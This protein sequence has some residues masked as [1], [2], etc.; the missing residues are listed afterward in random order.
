MVKKIAV[1]AGIAILVSLVIT[2][3]VLLIKYLTRDEVKTNVIY[4]QV[5]DNTKLKEA[6]TKPGD[7]TF[8]INTYVP[9]PD[10]TESTI[11][12]IYRTCNNDLIQIRLSSDKLVWD[13]LQSKIADLNTLQKKDYKSNITPVVTYTYKV[14]NDRSEVPR[15][16][17]GEIM[18]VL[19]NTN[20]NIPIISFMALN[21]NQELTAYVAGDGYK[22][23][24]NYTNS[25]RYE[26][27]IIKTSFAYNY[28]YIVSNSMCSNEDLYMMKD[29]L[30]DNTFTITIVDGIDPCVV[31]KMGGIAGHK[32]LI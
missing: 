25:A 26:P 16:G 10:T 14:V 11:N 1:I 4:K 29:K 31:Y 8:A 30:P 9:I 24:D 23:I 32:Y 2:G 13:M 18:P 7:F 5:M 15:V 3:L 28:D 21:Y 19:I 20:N 12:F 6:L 17:N 27:G 22:N